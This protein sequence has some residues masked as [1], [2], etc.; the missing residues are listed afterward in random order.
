MTEPSDGS[1]RARAADGG[2]TEPPF[3]APFVVETDCTRCPELVACRTEI[4]W[5]NGPRDASVVVVGEA[6]GAGDPTA[7]RWRGGNHTGAAY[8]TRHSG[9]RVRR[10]MNAVGH[11]DAYYTNAV[12]CF[13]C[14]GAGSNREPTAAERANCRSHLE[15]ELDE[16]DPEVVVSTG[17]HAT[18]TMLAFDGRELD[19]FLDSVLEPVALGAF[20]VTLLPLLHPSYQDVWLSRLGYTDAEY[21]EAIR[22]RL[23]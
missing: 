10:L 13:P 22:T 11:P 18:A 4:S 12:K 19:G 5:G 9:R 1:K 17:K 16:I 3:G 15:T 8:T 2:G 14:D 23:P 20:D 6:P 21:R 7:D